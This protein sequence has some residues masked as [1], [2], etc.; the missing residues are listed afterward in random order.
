[1]KENRVSFH[2]SFALLLCLSYNLGLG[3]TT[4]YELP[5]G[6]QVFVDTLSEHTIT[7]YQV[8]QGLITS[9]EVDSISGMAYLSVLGSQKNGSSRRGHILALPL[10]EVN[11]LWGKDWRFDAFSGN[12]SLFL[13]KNNHP[14]LVDENSAVAMDRLTGS[15]KWA[16]KGSDF[17]LHPNR[18]LLLGE[19]TDYLNALWDTQLGTELWEYHTPYNDLKNGSFVSDSC[20]VFLE[21]GIHHVDLYSGATWSKEEP[22][23]NGY[24]KLYKSP[25]RGAIVAASAV[26]FGL[27]GGT[28]AVMLTKAPTMVGAKADNRIF[29]NEHIY[30]SGT[31]VYKYDH[32]GNLIWTSE[33]NASGSGFSSI[34][35]LDTTLVYINYGYRYNTK[36]SKVPFGDARCALID[37]KTGKTNF[38]VILPTKGENYFKDFVIVDDEI[39]FLGQS[40]LLTLTLDSLQSTGS[41]E[42][43]TSDKNVGLSRFVDPSDYLKL[44][45][46]YIMMS[47]TL[48]ESL[49]ICNATT[50]VIE[51]N[52]S[53]EIEN[54][55]S[56][57]D[58]YSVL[59][60]YKDFILVGNG[61]KSVLIDQTGQALFGMTFTQK[62]KIKSGYLVDIFE[63][64]SEACLIK[65]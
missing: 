47:D 64:K 59:E 45:N 26:L 28:A 24:K 12:S 38:A 14:V 34:V 55:H 43:L 60:T 37:K 23:L 16:I 53:F 63:D 19:S 18:K 27:V 1:M 32:S 17:V 61:S 62:A 46:R 31:Y 7:R 54:V 56:I 13:T 41:N 65:L 4:G 2:W 58:V 52:A 6:H 35:S 15:E 3:Q 39:S 29:E 50:R 42:F 25:G 21:N 22:R 44:E 57:N 51:F 40:S 9:V 48:G 20:L 36:R 33:F 5:E 49:F 30:V 11:L 10:N 8:P